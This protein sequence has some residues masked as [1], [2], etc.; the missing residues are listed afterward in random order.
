MGDA[1]VQAEILGI[2][3]FQGIDGSFDREAY[4]FALQN[5]GLSE[6]EFET[7]IREEI[8]R[9]ILQ[10]ATV[11]GASAPEG[12]VQPLAGLPSADPRFQPC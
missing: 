12:L 9:S 11:G 4:R 3:S 2:S 8:A 7:S 6:G 10:L 1:T 5:A